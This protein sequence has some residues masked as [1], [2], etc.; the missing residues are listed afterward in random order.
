MSVSDFEEDQRQEELKFL[1][2][3]SKSALERHKEKVAQQK[4]Q[5]AEEKRMS[6]LERFGSDYDPTRINRPYLRGAQPTPSP[7]DSRTSALNQLNAG[8]RAEIQQGTATFNEISPGVYE[9]APLPF[10]PAQIEQHLIESLPS[11]I[12]SEVLMGDLRLQKDRAEFD[13]RA[14]P[15]LYDIKLT[16]QG[17]E[18]QQHESALRREYDP[19]FTYEGILGR[20]KQ[21]IPMYQR[22]TGIIAKEAPTG[23]EVEALREDLDQ[24]SLAERL[25]GNEIVTVSSIF[26]RDKGEQTEAEL[27]GLDKLQQELLEKGIKYDERIDKMSASG[28]AHELQKQIDSRGIKLSPTAQRALDFKL[29]QERF[30]TG[31]SKGALKLFNVHLTGAGLIAGAKVGGRLG[32]AA[33][34]DII[35]LD[36]G[37]Y[38]EDRKRISKRG[39]EH[40]REYSHI[41]NK[42]H[43]Q[44]EIDALKKSAN[45]AIEY[46]KADQKEK[47]AADPFMA[48]GEII[49]SVLTYTIPATAAA[50]ASASAARAA[51]IAGRA[52]AKGAKLARRSTILRRTGEA[53]ET[54][55]EPGEQFLTFVGGKIAPKT[56]KRLGGSLG[57]EELIIH[58]TVKTGAMLEKIS[59][60][61]IN[62]VRRSV[63]A[64]EIRRGTTPTMK[65]AKGTTKSSIKQTWRGTI[66]RTAVEPP[67]KTLDNEIQLWTDKPIKSI[68]PQGT[69]GPMYGTMEAVTVGREVIPLL[70]QK[71]VSYRATPTGKTEYIE[72]F[73]PW[74][75]PPETRPGFGYT[76]PIKVTKGKKS[77]TVNPFKAQKIET[78]INIANMINKAR[79]ESKIDKSRTSKDFMFAA[80][81]PVTPFAR[82]GY[83]TIT[84]IDFPGR[85]KAE[86][87]LQKQ[88]RAKPKARKDTAF[89]PFPRT[90]LRTRSDFDNDIL[91]KMSSIED[92]ISSKFAK[93]ETDSFSKLQSQ[94]STRV[95][96]RAQSRTETKVRSRARVRTRVRSRARAR[97]RVRTRVR[98]KTQVKAKATVDV[99]ARART[100][101][102]TRARARART[103]ARVNLPERKRDKKIRNT[104]GGSGGII[105]NEFEFGLAKDLNAQAKLRK[106]TMK[107]LAKLRAQ[108]K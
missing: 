108:V 25:Y 45:L 49:G 51:S 75:G 80:V 63:M 33:G 15:G 65:A 74:I 104:W 26:K 47:F 8:Q 99:E 16:R 13:E 62:R 29:K 38:G 59:V 31:I 4:A 12:Q 106:E 28:L 5:R 68:E 98:A 105:R 30:K 2:N 19:R 88:V 61:S 81:D 100:R 44:K 35:E 60:N 84:D 52:S 40:E 17:F 20:A 73:K 56:V 3:R 6:D 41:T 83:K 36:W 96:A 79:A 91:A 87:H 58:G 24:F 7:M 14:E 42:K 97:V 101:V 93:I 90:K 67:Q 107:D 32:K 18:R 54:L 77:K 103:R 50:K 76:A 70:R 34:R 27:E 10:T 46:M 21:L 9:F 48:S 71:D 85:F 66:K 102:R 86:Y 53:Y 64:R 89:K 69:V 95:R 55:I 23:Y 39:R 1:R 37:F 94:A 92:S 57:P 82:S 11:E 22:D 72:E 78:D 43:T